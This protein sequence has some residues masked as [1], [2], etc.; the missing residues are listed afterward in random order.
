MYL[1]TND[2]DTGVEVGTGC[3]VY[4]QNLSGENGAVDR[5]V[6]NP[7]EEVVLEF[8]PLVRV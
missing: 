8:L 6:F 3:T 2:L 5:A 1:T 7:W 4:A